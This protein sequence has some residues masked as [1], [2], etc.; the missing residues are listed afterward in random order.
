MLSQLGAA[1]GS[2]AIPVDRPYMAVLS[3]LFRVPHALAGAVMAQMWLKKIVAGTSVIF[4]V[5]A[6][7]LVLKVNSAF[8]L[9]AQKLRPEASDV[10]H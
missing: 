1:N 10:P 8:H 9:L 6:M 2:S 7:P 5:N 4:E 3:S